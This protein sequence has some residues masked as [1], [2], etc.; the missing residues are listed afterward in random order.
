[1]RIKAVISYD[2]SHFEGFQRQ[3][4]TRQTVTTAIEDVLND[5]NIQSRITGSGRTDTGVHATGQVIH[6]DLPPYWSDLRKLRDHLNTRLKY[7]KFKHIS[8]A[9]DNFHARFDAKRRI[10]RYIFTDREL[11]VFERD[12]VSHLRCDDCDKLSKAL[13]LFVGKHDFAYFHKSGS[14]PHSTIRTIYGAKYTKL[15]KYHA[16]YFEADGFLRSQVRM[17]IAAALH[18]ANDELSINQLQEQI[19]AK[20]RYTTDLAPAEGLYLARVI[21]T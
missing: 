12:F 21:Y 19:E 10:Y 5:L 2:G 13:R 8:P 14:D 4:R 1:M 17:M 18:T 16:I 11:S 9:R 15:G 3:T 6:L 7:I 20:K